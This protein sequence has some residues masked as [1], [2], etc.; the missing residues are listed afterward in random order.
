MLL[1]V[2]L[3]G[4]YAL[5]KQ[6]SMLRFAT[7]MHR[8]LSVQ[9][10]EVQLLQPRAHVA[11]IWPFGGFIGKWLGYVDKFLLFPRTLRRVSGNFDVIHICDHSNAMYSRYLSNVPHIVTCHDVL[12]IRSSLGEIAENAVSFTGRKFQSLI[13][14]GLREAQFIVCVSENTKK[15]LLRITNRP[16]EAVGVVYLCLNYPYTPMERDAA[17]ARLGHY[18]FDATIPFF[19]H[20]GNNSWYKNRL[21]VLEIFKSLTARKSSPK[22]LLMIGKPLPEVLLSYISENNLQDQVVTLS[23]L[24]NED[25][26]A[27]YSMATGLLF[28]SLQ[29]GFGWPILEAQACGCAVFA[30]G[31]PPMTEVGGEAA[32]YFDPKDVE[33]SADVVVAALERLEAVRNRGRSNASRFGVEQMMAG[34]TDAY[35]NAVRA[36]GTGRSTS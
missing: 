11:K 24:S 4:N 8:E 29:E 23:G 22:C 33:A 13:L 19:V 12:A 3:V 36:R 27:A 30:T 35:K 1:R 31:K 25:L 17:V 18:R 16:A 32:I 10:H 9:G 28:P 14:S 2:L 21:G 7:L 15:E 34:Y 20:V 26:R 5:D 6:E